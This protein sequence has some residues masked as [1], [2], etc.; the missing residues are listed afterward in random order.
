MRWVFVAFAI[1]MLGACTP[2]PGL[3]PTSTPGPWAD[4]EA[5]VTVLETRTDTVNALWVYH[6]ETVRML[7]GATTVEAGHARIRQSVAY[8]QGLTNLWASVEAGDLKPAVFRTILL[9]MY[10]RPPTE[11]GLTQ[12]R[13]ACFLEE[14][15][16]LT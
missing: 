14:C 12:H 9:E 2:V 4:L 8:D 1:I 16:T 5:R 3:A 13:K 7:T 15:G 10:F 6:R 11:E